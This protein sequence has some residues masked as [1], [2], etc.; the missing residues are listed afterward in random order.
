VIFGFFLFLFALT[1]GSP[2]GSVARIGEIEF[3]GT[4]GIDVPKVRSVLPVREGDEVYEDQVAGIREHIS[5][6]IANATGHPPTDI[7]LICCTDQQEPTIYIGL[8]GSN[9][10]SVYL[11]SAP[12]YSTCLP[13]EALTLYRQALD[14]VEPA[15]KSGNAGEDAP[16]S[17]MIPCCVRNNW[18]CVDMPY[19]MN[20]P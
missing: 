4:L 1:L 13:M 9:M 6:A 5:Q 19:T 17:P 11:R 15:V 7:S 16:P 14:A 12:K 8:R 10:A 18:L 3:F 2:H 20:E